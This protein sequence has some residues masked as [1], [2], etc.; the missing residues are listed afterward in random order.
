MDS[1]T[2]KKLWEKK[3]NQFNDLIKEVRNNLNEGDTYKVPKNEEDLHLL[4][5]IY[6]VGRNYG[7]NSEKLPKENKLAITQF[8]EECAAQWNDLKIDDCQI[9][10]QNISNNAF[11]LAIDYFISTAKAL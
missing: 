8:W 7:N 9:K 4:T 5:T 3:E 6:Y 11:L 1:L 2:F 10:L